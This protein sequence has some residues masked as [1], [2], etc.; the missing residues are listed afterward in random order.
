[1]ENCLT[2]ILE[3]CTGNIVDKPCVT[4]LFPSD[5]GDMVPMQGQILWW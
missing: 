4:W 5:F 1:M 3:F 2:C